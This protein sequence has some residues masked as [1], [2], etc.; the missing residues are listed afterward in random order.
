LHQR[1]GDVSRGVPERY[2]T[3]NVKN[4]LP[5]GIAIATTDST[6]NTISDVPP[7]MLDHV[8]AMRKNQATMPVTMPTTIPDTMATILRPIFD[9]CCRSGGTWPI[10]FSKLPSIERYRITRA[11]R[12]GG[13]NDS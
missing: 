9:Y 13:G 4:P 12:E 8:A 3:Q 7:W 6:V 11:P 2:T 5:S 1:P 10:R